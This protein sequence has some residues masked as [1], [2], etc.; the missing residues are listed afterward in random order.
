MDSVSGGEGAVST[1]IENLWRVDTVECTN[2]RAFACEY[3]P[4]SLKRCLISCIVTVLM[5]SVALRL[6]CLSFTKS[7]VK[8]RG[9]EC[10]H[11]TFLVVFFR[12]SH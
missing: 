10:D 6:K 7:V 1:Y 8:L 5:E 4:F 2:L 3:K 9:Y 12:A 11:H